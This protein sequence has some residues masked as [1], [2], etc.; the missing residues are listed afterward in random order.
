MKLALDWSLFH[1]LPYEL[2]LPIKPL[3]SSFSRVRSE[4]HRGTVV[5]SRAGIRE[6]GIMIVCRIIDRELLAAEITQR[7]RLGC[8][9]LGWAESESGLSAWEGWRD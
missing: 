3:F 2:E 5:G 7:A 8:Q 4:A 6:S 9:G 1:Y